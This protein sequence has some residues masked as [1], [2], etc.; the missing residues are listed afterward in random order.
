MEAI[1]AE[2]EPIL[3]EIAIQKTIIVMVCN[4]GQSELLMNF[5][6]S[7]K[8]RNLDIR[9][10]LVFTTD[11]ETADLAESI[12]LRAYYDHIVRTWQARARVWTA[13]TTTNYHTLS[14]FS[15]C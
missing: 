6:C 9:N 4:F 12:G 2:L 11:Q 1:K 7:A 5:V 13:R 8:A 15:H 3:K 14:H 10:I